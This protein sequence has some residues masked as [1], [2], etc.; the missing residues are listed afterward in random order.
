M[1]SNSVKELDGN[2]YAL[3]LI[4]ECSLHDVSGNLCETVAKIINESHAFILSLSLLLLLLLSYENCQ[5]QVNITQQY[6][7]NMIKKSMQYN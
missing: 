2:R 7:A 3:T 4:E 5:A 6:A 1:K